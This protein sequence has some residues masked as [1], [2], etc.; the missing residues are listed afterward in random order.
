MVLFSPSPLGG[1]EI[2]MEPETE[3]TKLLARGRRYLKLKIFV[4]S[5]QDVMQERQRLHRVVHA[6]NRSGGAADQLGVVFEVLDWHTHVAPFMGRPE[7]VIIDQLP[8]EMWDIFVGIL[9]MR[10]GMPTGAVDKSSQRAFSS[11]T[12]EE[13]ALAYDALGKTGRP[14]ILFYQCLRSP[15]DIGDID[16]DQWARVKSFFNRFSADAEHPGLV[17]P[18][19]EFQEFEEH[20]TRDLV[21]L[22][23]DF[24]Q[25]QQVTDLDSTPEDRVRNRLQAAFRPGQEERLA[26]LSIDMVEHSRLVKRYPAP[27]IKALLKAYREMVYAQF[28][29]YYGGQLNWAS[30]GGLFVF[31]GHEH[32]ERAVLAGINILQSILAFNLDKARNPLSDAIQVR[33]A[34]HEG[35]VEFQWPTSEISSEVI[36]FVSKLE[37]KRTRGGEFC[38]TGAVYDGLGQRLQQVF[39]HKSR[40]DDKVI[41]VF[42]DMQNNSRVSGEEVA[43]LVTALRSHISALSGL[44]DA[45]GGELTA[46]DSE[47]LSRGFDNVYS[48]IEQFCRWFEQIDDRWA[49][50]YFKML[51]RYASEILEEE[52]LFWEGFHRRY[53]SL[54]KED[55]ITED[56]RAI[57]QGGGSRRSLVVAELG[58]ILNTVRDRG[59]SL[60]P[61]SAP[62][63]GSSADLMEKVGRLI[64][65]DDLEEEPAFAELMLCDRDQIVELLASSEGSRSSAL[66]ESL[67]ALLDLVL[68]ED[69][70]ARIRGLA[71]LLNVL[72]GRPDIGWK[73][74]LIQEILKGTE[75]PSAEMV[76]RLFRRLGKDLSVSDYQTILL[77]LVVGHPVERIRIL[78]AAEVDFNRLWRTIAYAKAPIGAILAVEKR[79]KSEE[80]DDRKK[81]FFDCVRARIASTISVARSDEEM[82]E[83]QRLILGLFH[84]DF[85]VQTGYFERL[86]DLLSRFL[87]KA[88]QFGLDTTTFREVIKKLDQERV[89]KGNPAATLPKGLGG[90]PKAIQ[91]RLAREGL[92]LD[93]FVLHPDD[94]I[95][96]ETLC[97]ITEGRLE[98]VLTYRNVNRAVWAD[99]LRRPEVLT[100][101]T[102]L[103]NVLHHPKCDV[104][105]AQKYKVQL[106]F[107]EQKSLWQDGGANSQVRR[108]ALIA[109]LHH[110]KCEIDFAQ[111]SFP[112]LSASE[113]QALSRDVRA[114]PEVRRRAE[115]R[116]HGSV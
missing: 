115:A 103:V 15:Q 64:S 8:V 52:K 75:E 41:Y 22:L 12:E 21:N 91:R 9:W 101:H 83:L 23:K 78:A 114:N 80:G 98:R 111:Q 33:I 82:V 116:V 57:L 55:P 17:Q 113:R 74:R 105:F 81:I 112:L 61:I 85:F 32:C 46:A 65:A 53:S 93:F 19:R 48:T 1:I 54:S 42:P 38:V 28:D 60:S 29:R 44:L 24:L 73:F 30:D 40:F 106:S 43:R 4:A 10:F 36:N 6:L 34:A 14:K 99:L 104:G 25:N 2:G 58:Q 31:W 13:F 79:L 70:D 59:L 69:L 84:F 35:L 39:S 76:G 97:H 72:A 7:K 96:R 95:A 108:F 66:A 51:T 109:A 89:E 45:V 63:D 50:D 11:G 62:R 107:P 102:T 18:F 77:A 3:A 67:W 47:G 110:P 87:N 94:R 71:V 26:V 5:P 88:G 68:M 86:N 20:L 37:K 16:P 27:D 100:R 90:I 56:L 92:Y 49:H